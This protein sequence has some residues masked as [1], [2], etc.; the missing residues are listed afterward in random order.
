VA[1]SIFYALLEE[2][3]I[4]RNVSEIE[5]FI[6]SDFDYIEQSSHSSDE[7]MNNIE[8]DIQNGN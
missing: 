5:D 3:N 2:E 6:D 1:K 4:K 7:I 8:S